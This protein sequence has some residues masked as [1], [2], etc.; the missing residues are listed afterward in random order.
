MFNLMVSWLKK[1][2]KKDTLLWTALNYIKDIIMFTPIV[3]PI[4]RRISKNSIFIFKSELVGAS[5]FPV[6]L[7]NKTVELFSPKMVLDLGCGTGKSLDY[8]LSKRIEVIGV[9]G[10]KIAISAANH[11]ELI[12]KYNLEKEL[13]LNKRFD[14]IWS[15]EFVEHIHPKFIDNLLKTF[16]NHSN[17]IVLSAARPGQGGN[18]HFNEQPE[19]YWVKQFEKYGYRSNRDKIEELRNI[20]ELYAKNMLVF[21]R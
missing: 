5:T 4:Y 14:L 2:V 15:F 18:G 6:K 9:E 20:D 10:S 17:R 12:I 11:P 1:R 21:E 3:I 8:F 16:S 19:A 13:K 7:I